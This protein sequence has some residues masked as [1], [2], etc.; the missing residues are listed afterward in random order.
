MCH[1]DAKACIVPSR[2][3]MYKLRSKCKREFGQTIKEYFNYTVSD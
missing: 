3:V 1:N 2:R